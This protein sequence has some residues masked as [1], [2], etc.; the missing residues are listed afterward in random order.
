MKVETAKTGLILILLAYALE[1]W[2]WVQQSF[3]DEDM[4]QSLRGALEQAYQESKA[5]QAQD[6]EWLRAKMR[7][8]D[9]DQIADTGAQLRDLGL[10]RME[11][12]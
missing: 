4:R 8:M 1:T 9:D 5:G 6:P 2:P 12:R 11:E 10:R 7:Q 3:R